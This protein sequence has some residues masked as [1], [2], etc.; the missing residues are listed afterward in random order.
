[1][2][3]RHELGANRFIRKLTLKSSASA[4]HYELMLMA[5]ISSFCNLLSVRTNTIVLNEQLRDI[6]RQYR[7]LN[8]PRNCFWK[9][10]ASHS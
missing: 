8:Q 7:H 2:C 6:H 5:K 3:E 10:T 9:V 4:P 1:M